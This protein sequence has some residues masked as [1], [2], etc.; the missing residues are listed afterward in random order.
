MNTNPERL[1]L[2]AEL[3]QIVQQ[4][5]PSALPVQVDA[6]T[7]AT[8]K[9][10][11]D[12]AYWWV[13]SPDF[14][15]SLV[16][17]MERVE[18][19]LAPQLMNKAP[20]ASELFDAMEA[21]LKARIGRGYASIEGQDVRK[22]LNAMTPEE[23]LSVAQDLRMALQRREVG[24]VPAEGTGDV[25]ANASASTPTDGTPFMKLD[26]VGKRDEIA[27]R[28]GRD[29][30]TLLPSEIQRFSREIEH[31]EKQGANNG[32]PVARQ[33]T[34]PAPTP[35][36]FQSEEFLSKPPAERIRLARAAEKA[37]S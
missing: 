29:P 35:A 7:D 30:S 8:L 13:R 27:K 17:T 31:M 11:G 14:R 10:L 2:R 18:N 5:H 1:K 20:T 32:K 34:S 24:E 3:R 23:R 19:Y 33:Q 26:G 28:L 16:I 12:N 9:E 6:M 22:K 21:D 37:K 36:S 4:R 25:L 15:Q